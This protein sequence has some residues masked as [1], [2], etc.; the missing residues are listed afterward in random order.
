MM[1]N[2]VLMFGV[3]GAVGCLLGCLLGEG[4]LK[5]GLPEETEA[6][7]PSLVAS[8]EPPVLSSTGTMAPEVPEIP[9]L[10]QKGDKAD[11][12]PPPEFSDRL[13]R[14]GGEQFGDVRITLIWNDYND[15]DLHCIDPNGEEIFFSHKRSDSNG[16]LDVDK[17]IF[18]TTKQPVEN[19]YWPKGGAPDGRYRVFV[20]YYNHWLGSHDSPYKVNV[21]VEGE[22][23]SFEGTISDGDLKIGRAS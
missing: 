10:P 2:K 1:K 21:S 9:E 18:P 11:K 20:N 6:S 22:Q 4:L 23:R 3:T 5:V 12:P 14:E 17:N 8:P 7:T 13:K 19:I 16:E 15:L